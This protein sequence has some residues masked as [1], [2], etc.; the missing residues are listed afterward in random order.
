MCTLAA[1]ACF[2]SFAISPQRNID[3]VED[4]L[5]KGPRN[6]A[7]RY[8]YVFTFLRVDPPA[9][10]KSARVCDWAWDKR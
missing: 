1:T 9:I 8:G 7:K 2:W 6:N 10:P 3:V 5:M 4:E